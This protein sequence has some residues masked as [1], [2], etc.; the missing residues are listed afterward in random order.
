MPDLIARSFAGGEVAPAIYGRADVV[1]YQTGLRTCRNF[2]VRR[3]GGVS[4]RPGSQYITPQ[5]DHSARGRMLK[6]IFNAEQT[7]VLLFENQTMRVV[8]RGILLTVPDARAWSA[9]ATITAATQANPCVITAVAHGFLN[10]D[11]VTITGVTGMTQLNGNSYVVANQT[12][13]TFELQGIDSTGY[14]AYV[15]AGTATKNYVA[16]D[17]VSS[18]AVNY[19]CLLAH[20]GQMPPNALYWYAMPT[21]NVYEIPTPFFTPHLQTLYRS[22]SGDVVTIT[23]TSYRIYDLSRTGHTTWVFTLVS[24]A[25]SIAAPPTLTSSPGGAAARVWRVT[26]VKKETYEESERSVAAFD[27]APTSV[28]PVTLTIGAVA[29][30]LEYNVYKN[31]GSGIFGFIGVS[32]G[33]TFVDYGYFPNYSITPPAARDP[34]VGENDHPAC[35]G[36]LQQ[37][38]AYGGLPSNPESA[39]LSKTGQYTNFGISSPLRLD[40]ACTYP[41]ASPQVNTVRHLIEVLE[42]FILTAGVEWVALGGLDGQ[43]TPGSPGLKPKSFYGSSEVPPVIIGD[44]VLFVQ[45]RGSLVRDLNYDSA[46]KGYTGRDLSVFVPHLFAGKT[47][48]HW[49]YAQIP[50]SIV[51]AVQDDGS[52]IGLTYM[53]DQDVWGWH[54]HDTDGLYEDVVVV[55]EGTEDAH[56]VLVNRT[57][58]GATRRYLERFASRRVTDMEVDAIFM[59]SYLTYDGR[60][61]TSTTMTLSGGVDWLSTEDLTLTSSAGFF[62]AGDVGNAIR[63]RITEEFYTP[64]GNWQSLTTSLI[65]TI[66]DY[67]SPTEATVTAERDVPVSFQNYTTTL[68][69]KGVDQLSGLDHLEG[70][71]VAILADGHVLTNGIDEPF[72]TVV[73]GGFTLDRPYFVIHAGLP[74][75]SDLETLDLELIGNETLTSKQKSVNRVDLLVEASRGLWTGEDFSHLREWKQRTSADAYGLI[76]VFTGHVSVA[77]GASWNQGGRVCVRQRDPL[78]LTVLNVTPTVKIGG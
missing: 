3:H 11:T 4:N 51:W 38:K 68:W 24:M 31:E 20:V 37:R 16:G 64:E 42:T 5:R 29:G 70:K 53:R 21:D 76:P 78:P 73:S 2:I 10:G 49:D 52:L 41:I 32:N 43:L 48:E 75:C 77:I 61:T 50:D 69:A 6:F 54:R 57:I 72:T 40:D 58:N 60:N 47:I 55:P 19:Y 71:T 8:Q 27:Q 9:A 22:Q 66:T 23:H 39:Y 13:D 35:S 12:V 65:L 67:V 45:D 14:G 34:F 63:L 25:P 30:A 59:D 1:K 26:A 44:N 74:Y 62:L 15:A 28:I 33:P 7:Y 56:Y 18:V 36:Y 17:V 46:T